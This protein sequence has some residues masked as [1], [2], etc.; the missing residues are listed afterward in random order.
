MNDDLKLSGHIYWTLL[1]K[2]GYI[3][4]GETKNVITTYGKQ[5]VASIL[6]T[7]ATNALWL[8][9]GT[10]IG[11]NGAVSAADNSLFSEVPSVGYGYT[12]QAVTKQAVNNTVQ[13]TAYIKDF[14]NPIVI[15]EVGLF[16]NSTI[17]STYLVAHQLLGQ[18]PVGPTYIGLQ[19]TWVVSLN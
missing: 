4:E 6:G 13:Y 17:G 16:S 19:I 14:T 12:R 11:P 8:A 9:A 7:G 3:L 18:I 10:S 15:R 2:D 5:W 1:G